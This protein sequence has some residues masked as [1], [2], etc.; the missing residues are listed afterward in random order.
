MSLSKPVAIFY[1]IKINERTTF[2]KKKLVSESE[3]G[4]CL[5]YADKDDISEDDDDSSLERPSSKGS[6]RF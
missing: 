1:V 6:S 4:T 3:V 2:S 5:L